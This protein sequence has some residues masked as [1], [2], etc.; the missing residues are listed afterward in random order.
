MRNAPNKECQLSD[1]LKEYNECVAH[2]INSVQ[3]QK[4]RDFKHHSVISCY[5][6]SINVSIKSYK[7][8]KLLGFNYKS[9]AIGGLL[10]DLFLYD[11]HT[12]KL[13]DGMH[14]FLHPK[15][16]LGN[17]VKLLELNKIEKDIIIKHM[18]P[19]TMV[20]PFYRESIVVC[21]VDKYCAITETLSIYFK[22]KNRI[23]S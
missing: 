20:P 15:I 17:A 4:M 22:L 1:D 12:T 9:A 14:G 8:C 11:W 21:L 6:H 7:L 16:A 10:H 2:I 19:L 23:L 13:D 3:V 18:F 5:E